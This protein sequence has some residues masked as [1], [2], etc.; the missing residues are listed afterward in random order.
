[1]ELDGR[2][3]GLVAA[4]SRYQ[5]T[6]GVAFFLI[7]FSIPVLEKGYLGF[8]VGL[9]IRIMVSEMMLRVDRVSVWFCSMFRHERCDGS[10]PGCQEGSWMR[11]NLG[12]GAAWL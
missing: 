11:R 2:G 9:K 4:M 10:S 7:F 1:M 8:L 12:L 3:S 5:L 6:A